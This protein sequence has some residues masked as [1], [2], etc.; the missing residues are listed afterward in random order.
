MINT[1]GKLC[2]VTRIT[3][4]GFMR[5]IEVEL[6][7]A[8]Y[9]NTYPQEKQ[10]QY[11]LNNTS[12]QESQLTLTEQSDIEAGTPT[13]Q[14]NGNFTGNYSPD[15]NQIERT[16]TIYERHHQN[17]NEP[18]L[19]SITQGFPFRLSLSKTTAAIVGFTSINA[20]F[21]ASSMLGALMLKYDV[22]EVG[23]D[24]AVGSGMQTTIGAIYRLLAHGPGLR[25]S[26]G[27]PAAEQDKLEAEKRTLVLLGYF[28]GIFSP[29]FSSGIVGQF[30]LHDG[31]FD[32]LSP[33]Q[34]LFCS[35]SGTLV[36][37]GALLLLLGFGYHL[38]KSCC[39]PP[40]SDNS[41]NLNSASRPPHTNEFPSETPNTTHATPHRFR[42]FEYSSHA[43][44]VE[45][46]PHALT[47]VPMAV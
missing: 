23:L 37:G 46:S 34:L 18:Q 45:F 5:N 4:T 33:K 1:T 20:F 38:T 24:A 36:G 30:F 19:T 47:D 3:I 40:S 39:N 7:V 21:T 29:A 28:F 41:I 25:A 27:T 16:E 12:T 31:A 2:P 15:Q 6:L 13:I 10:H 32:G 14:T 26:P 11:E 8:E 17:T 9:L 44:E 42:F 22:Y 43:S 35:L